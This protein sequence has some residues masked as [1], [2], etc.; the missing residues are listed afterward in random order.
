MGDKW[1]TGTYGLIKASGRRE[2]VLDRPYPSGR[3]PKECMSR[4]GCV[5]RFY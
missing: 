3:E 5:A 4:H 2:S 1:S